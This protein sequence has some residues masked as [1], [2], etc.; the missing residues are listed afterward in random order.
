M[1]VCIHISITYVCI[2]IIYAYICIH[3]CIH[4]TSSLS[5]HPLTDT[6]VASI[7][8][9]L[10]IIMQWIWFISLWDPAF[11]F[12]RH[13]TPRSEIAGH[14][15]ILIWIFWENFIFTILGTLIYSLIHKCSLFFTCLPMLVISCLFGDSC[16][17]RC[18]VIYHCGFNLQF[19][20]D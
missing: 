10:W 12:L 16:C 17:N 14:K 6:Y 20:D 11:I 13:I 1:C 5:I 2:N 15:V 3:A 7:S 9:L 18:E 8:W 19:P 4:I